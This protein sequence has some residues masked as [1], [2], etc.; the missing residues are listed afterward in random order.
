MT[1]SVKKPLWSVAL[2]VSLGLAGP[3][4]ADSQNL[5]NMIASDH[6]VLPEV[7]GSIIAIRQDSAGHVYV[8]ASPGHLVQVF[9][10]MGNKVA[11]IPDAHSAMAFDYAADL[12][13]APNGNIVVADRGA[14]TIDVFGPDGLLKT[15][16]TVFAPTSL[17]AL[18]NG[19]I[20]VTTLRTQH[21]IEIFE[22]NG[23]FVR[24]F[25]E[26]H[27][28]SNP[29]PDAPTTPAPP[30]ADTGRIIGDSS[31]N[32]YFGILS[33]TD[34]QVKKFDRFGYAAYSANVPTP[35]DIAD[36]PEDRV[37]FGFNFSRLTSADQI[38]SWTTVGD[39]GNLQFGS[40]VGMGLAGLMSGEG[41]GGRGRNGGSVAATVTAQT[42]LVQ[43][44]FDVHVGMNTSNRGGRGRPAGQ[45]PPTG[46]QQTSSPASQGAAANSASL[47]YFAPGTYSS[48]DDSSADDS[49]ADSDSAGSTA[50]SSA[51]LQYQAPATPTSN[52]TNIVPGALDYMTGSPLGFASPTTGVGG[53]SSFF[54][55]RFGPRPGGFG[56]PLLGGAGVGGPL[57]H[58]AGAPGALSAAGPS[59]A[60]TGPSAGAPSASGAKPGFGH[61]RFGASDVS[62]VG[63]MR[64]NLDRPQP[65]EPTSKMLTA[66]GIDHQTQEVWAAVGPILVHFDKYGNAMDTYYL[67]APNGALLQTTAIVVDPNHLLIG[68]SSGGIYY[69]T[70]PDKLA[71]QHSLQVRAKVPD[72]PTR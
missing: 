49:A 5:H 46:S 57:G 14:N 12:D 53:F 18:S 24:G 59:H 37:Q 45:A 52:P 50:S 11:Q 36:T 21:P 26:P 23:R 69:F 55:G 20:A 68:T 6:R 65:V 41:R 56:H 35:P 47:Q 58:P 62:F 25:G 43:P 10:A 1:F 51:S 67:T 32:L 71:D 31:D 17:V 28:I 63:S 4:P 61:G 3:R 19:Q 39:T 48:S 42:S 70:R 2:L 13:I 15:K 29:S 7:G 66:I 34:P 33:P 38:G 72:K 27:D 22:Q 9:D 64:I 8:I 30:L 60:S 40:N 54:L 16:F 44:T